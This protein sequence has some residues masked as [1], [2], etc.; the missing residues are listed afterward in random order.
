MLENLIYSQKK[1]LLT[2]E[3]EAGNVPENAIAFIGDTDQIYTQGRYF[4]G[5]KWSIINKTVTFIIQNVEYQAEKGMTWGEWCDS[6]YNTGGFTPNN[7]AKIYCGGESFISL[8]TTKNFVSLD[9]AIIS[10]YTYFIVSSG[11]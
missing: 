2:K 7:N 11:K 4:G 9:D 1:S 3:L 6:D 8:D 5:A 10:N